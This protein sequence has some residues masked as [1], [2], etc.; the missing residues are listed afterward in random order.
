MTLTTSDSCSGFRLK[1]PNQKSKV[2]TS[3]FDRRTFVPLKSRILYRF[4]LYKLYKLYVYYRYFT[5]RSSSRSRS[6]I[7]TGVM[8]KEKDL[9]R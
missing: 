2:M 5:S 7:S 4:H 3:Y 9:I 6:T 1:R 8:T